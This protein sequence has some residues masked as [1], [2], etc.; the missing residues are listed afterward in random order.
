MRDV[1]LDWF[2]EAGV[3]AKAYHIPPRDLCHC[4]QHLVK[5]GREFAVVG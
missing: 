1:R 4:E 2:Q 5:L 3:V